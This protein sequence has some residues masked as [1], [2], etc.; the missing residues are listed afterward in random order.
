MKTLTIKSR[1]KSFSIDKIIGCMWQLST[2]LPCIRR[3]NKTVK[4]EDPLR[5]PLVMCRY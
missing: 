1:L 5:F 4:S 2:K 3:L